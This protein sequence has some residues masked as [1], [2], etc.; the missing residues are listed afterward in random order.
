MGVC[1]VIKGKL[2]DHYKYACIHTILWHV[3]FVWSL[4]K[5]LLSYLKCIEALPA[6]F[7]HYKNLTMICL[8][9]CMH[10]CVPDCVYVCVRCI[11]T[12][13]IYT[14]LIWISSEHTNVSSTT[15]FKSGSPEEQLEKCSVNLFAELKSA[16]IVLLS[17]W[18]KDSVW[19]IVLNHWRLRWPQKLGG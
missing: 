11:H 8:C 18:C 16:Y 9:E 3:N 12:I 2:M 5:Q 15:Q 17:L 1:F 6:N 10:M 7:Q 19:I 14:Y 13:Y 4:E